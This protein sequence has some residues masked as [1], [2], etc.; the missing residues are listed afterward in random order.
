MF[1]FGIEWDY[2]DSSILLAEGLGVGFAVGVEE[3]LRPPCDAFFISG[4]VI[5][6]EADAQ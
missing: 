6:P 1:A 2:R 4:V 5:V 3:V